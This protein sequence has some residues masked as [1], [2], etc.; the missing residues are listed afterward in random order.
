MNEFCQ[1]GMEFALALNK[2]GASSLE[3]PACSFHSLILS[4]ADWTSGRM[5]GWMGGWVVRWT[6]GRECAV[7]AR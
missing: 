2:F 5:D 6:N 1:H 3:L 7:E 4:L